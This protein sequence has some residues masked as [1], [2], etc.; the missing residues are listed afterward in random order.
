MRTLLLVTLAGA[1][2]A[3]TPQNPPPSAEETSATI[4]VDVNVVNVL[5]SVRDKRGGL[6]ANLDR[7]DFAISRTANRR[8]LSTSPARPIFR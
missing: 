3:Q 1:L 6:V 8:I 7:N 5:A 4:Q 2:C